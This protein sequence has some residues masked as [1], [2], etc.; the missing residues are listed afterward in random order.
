MYL[1]RWKMPPSASYLP[2][3]LSLVIYNYDTIWRFMFTIV[4]MLIFIYRT[5]CKN[6][7]EYIF[8]LPICF[9]Y[10]SLNID[11]NMWRHDGV[12]RVCFRLRFHLCERIDLINCL[13]RSHT[14]LHFHSLPSRSLDS[15]SAVLKSSPSLSLSLSL[16]ALVS[17]ARR[18]LLSWLWTSELSTAHVYGTISVLVLCSS[19]VLKMKNSK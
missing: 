9:V 14:P 12:A 17:L 4:K 5:N 16:S 7:A 15:H 2:Y 10:P 18:S 6:I 1:V 8:D 13:P 11:L 19:N 3:K